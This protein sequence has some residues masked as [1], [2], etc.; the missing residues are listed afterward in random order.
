MQLESTLFLLPHTGASE[1]APGRERRTLQQVPGKEC[2]ID[3]LFRVP[4]VRK[5]P[6]ARSLHA[7][8]YL[9]VHVVSTWFA[10]LL[11]P[12]NRR[13][14]PQSNKRSNH[15]RDAKFPRT[16][17]PYPSAKFPRQRRAIIQIVNRKS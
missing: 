13:I 7:A 16:V 4:W 17:P 10:P 5:A 11:A 2:E 8:G 12:G 1:E 6:P 3:Q 9:V 14:V 15:E